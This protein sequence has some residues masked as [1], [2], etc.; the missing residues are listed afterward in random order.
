MRNVILSIIASITIVSCIEKAKKEINLN[1]IEVEVSDTQTNVK[2]KKSLFIG[3]SH[4]ANKTGWGWQSIVC[5]ETGMIETNL[6]IGGKQTS[7]MIQIVNSNVSSKY[8]YCFIYGGSN[9]YFGSVPTEKI[10][11]N[12]QRMV[13]TCNTR[14][15]TP[16]VLTGF[17]NVKCTTVDGKIKERGRLFKKSLIENIKNAKILDTRVIEITDCGDKLCHMKPSGHKKVANS[18]IDQMKFERLEK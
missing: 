10:I 1:N 18:V 17:D 13:D 15:V 9:D 3:D 5:K 2:G 11:S 16:I 7:W 4:T 12:I 14:K 8:D 6:A